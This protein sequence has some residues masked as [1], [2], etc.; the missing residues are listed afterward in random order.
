MMPENNNVPAVK[1]PTGTTA[2]LELFY[3]YLRATIISPS[4]FNI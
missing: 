4:P 2:N 1:R 3:P